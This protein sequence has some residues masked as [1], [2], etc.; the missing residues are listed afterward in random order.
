[1]VRGFWLVKKLWFI[2]PVNSKKTET[3][4]YP[5]KIYF[6]K[7]TDHTFYEF[8]GVLTHLGCWENTQKLVNYEPNFNTSK[9]VYFNNNVR[10]LLFSKNTIVTNT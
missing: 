4:F 6:V 3:F 9:L 5:R 2:V 10:L 8:T 7:A 1:M